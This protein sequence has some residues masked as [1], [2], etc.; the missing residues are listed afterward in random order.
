MHSHL[1]HNFKTRL[2]R[3]VLQV[4]KQIPINYLIKTDMKILNVSENSIMVV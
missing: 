2:I 1:P 3:E 4:Q